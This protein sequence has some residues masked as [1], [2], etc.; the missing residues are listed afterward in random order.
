MQNT[1]PLQKLQFDLKKPSWQLSKSTTIK[2]KLNLG[3]PE[4][5]DSVWASKGRGKIT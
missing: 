2:K 3:Y 5:L 4:L 1:K